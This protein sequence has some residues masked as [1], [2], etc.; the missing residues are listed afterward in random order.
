MYRYLYLSLGSVLFKIS[1]LKYHVSRQGNV[2]LPSRVNVCLKAL[3]EQDFFLS[4]RYTEV[5]FN[6]YFDSYAPVKPFCWCLNGIGKEIKG[7]QNTAHESK[8]FATA[9]FSTWQIALELSA[10]NSGL[11]LVRKVVHEQDPCVL[12]A[13]T[14]AEV[15]LRHELRD[16]RST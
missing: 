15:L 13:E 1:V 7:R 6:L 11:V 8:M 9:L 5:F 12:C 10:L 16:P 14:V 4:P 3:Q 2:L